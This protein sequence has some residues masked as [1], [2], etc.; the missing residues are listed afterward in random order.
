MNASS[1][2]R[3]VSGNLA[4]GAALAALAWWLLGLQ[5]GDW[6]IAPPQRR[7]VWMAAAAVLAY[8]AFCAL[9]AWRSRDRSPRLAATADRPELLVAWASQTGF[10]RELA[11]RSV[12]LLHE[13]GQPARQL[14]LERLDAPTLASSARILFIA[15]TTGEGDPP[16]HALPFLRQVMDKATPLPQLHYAVLALGDRKYGDFC[17]FGRELDTWLRQQGAHP[18]CDRLE[19]D[20]ADAATLRH[21]QHLLGRI[22][23]TSVATPGWSGPD[24]QSWRLQWRRV[25]NPGSVGGAVYELAL[26]PDG[27]ALPSW[28]AGDIAEV[29]PR[30]DPALVEAWLAAHRLDG[31]TPVEGHR[32]ASTLRELAA[33]SKLP[34]AIGEQD[35]QAL[36]ASLEPLPHREYSIASVPAEGVVK[37][38]LRR[39]LGADGRPGIGSGWLCDYAEVGGPIAMRLRSN[40]AF[41]PPAMDL[42]LILIGNGTGIAGLRA[43]LRAR[44]EA[45]ARRTWLLYGERHAA[46]DDHYGTELRQW[47]AEGWLE[48]LDAVFSRDGGPHR[49]VQDVLDDA[50]STLRAWV[51]AGASIYVCGSAR[52]MAPGVDGVIERALGHERKETLLLQGRYRRDVY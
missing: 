7:H 26:E 21:W 20:N 2:F 51:D 4:V 24:Y 12:A 29:G 34:D 45:G 9:V 28:Q 17:Q 16:D 19:V 37:L 23:G 52:H 27:F 49:Y 32:N 33:R 11:T 42:P 50:A 14:P 36:A 25:T 15:S 39:Q 35:A 38:L 31:D 10:A 46:C 5:G 8:A 47:Q 6:W 13:L 1:S 30:H 22:A 40:P 48:R 44:I 18:L 43:Q 3:T 41:H